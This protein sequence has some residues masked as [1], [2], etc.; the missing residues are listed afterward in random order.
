MLKTIVLDPDCI[1]N[2]DDGPDAKKY[3]NEKFTRQ[4]KYE[5]Y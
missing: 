2:E 3:E 5:S 4:I 1:S